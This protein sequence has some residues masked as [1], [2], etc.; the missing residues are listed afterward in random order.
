[1]Y[2]FLRH[3]TK[4][5]ERDRSWWCRNDGLLTWNAA[6]SSTET[7]HM[8]DKCDPIIATWSTA[9]DN[10][11]VKNVEKFASVR[12]SRMKLPNTKNLHR[13]TDSLHSP[14]TECPTFVFQAL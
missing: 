4:F 9:G 3:A 1:M 5:E 6:A 7:Y 10:F 14:S 8:I 2:L 11:V 12:M 13:L